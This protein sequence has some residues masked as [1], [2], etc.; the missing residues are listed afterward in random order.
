ENPKCFYILE[1]L[2]AEAPIPVWHDD[3]QGT[4]AVTVA[5]L[6]N[7]LKIVKKGMGDARITLIGVG[8]AN[9]C[10]ARM[11]V[12][13]GA[14]AKKMLIVD[15]KA[16]LSK[17]RDDIDAKTHRQKW[18][19]CRITNGEGRDGN[20]AEALVGQDVVIALAKSGP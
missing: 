5:G 13:A 12:K 19:L 7:A 14:D 18:E 20:M 17:R 8:A 6:I 9:V 16:I 11:L 3:Q 1:R 4:A 15:S 10:T 2:R